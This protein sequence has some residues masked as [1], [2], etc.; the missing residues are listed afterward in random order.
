MSLS[1]DS[2]LGHNVP[3][4]SLHDVDSLMQTGGLTV[5]N[6]PSSPR[7]HGGGRGEGGGS[8]VSSVG[9]AD[10][11]DAM[12]SGHWRPDML[13]PL[14]DLVLEKGCFRGLRTK[15]KEES[16]AFEYVANGLQQLGF[17]RFSERSL[18]KKLRQQVESF[19]L[20]SKQYS[21]AGVPD[22]VYPR[23]I[24]EALRVIAEKSHQRGRPKGGNGKEDDDSSPP[25][26][27]R[28]ETEV[29]AHLF[30]PHVHQPLGGGGAALPSSLV[31]MGEARKRRKEGPE[32]GL[33]VVLK[34]TAELGK[35]MSEMQRTMMV[36]FETRTSA[37]QL[38]REESEKLVKTV[39][40]TLQ[41]QLEMTKAVCDGQKE[42]LVA[43]ANALLPQ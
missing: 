37:V 35:R 25:R 8:V 41:Q 38:Q 10:G 12:N 42:V 2:R 27:K 13:E 4:V 16:S 31:G 3:R 15:G 7:S 5:P 28:K 1:H 26:R 23:K 11:F 32:G 21:E 20:I 18:K 43:M 40:D 34:M 9:G 33:E 14:L 36:M 19:E 6:I 39:Q 22:S 29:D 17:P 30:T 24:Q